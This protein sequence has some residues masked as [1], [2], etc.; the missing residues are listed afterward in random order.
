VFT[1]FQRAFFLVDKGS[2][3]LEIALQIFFDFS[4]QLPIYA[5]NHPT[6]RMIPNFSRIFAMSLNI[7]YKCMKDG[8]A[9]TVV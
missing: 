1:A 7:E 8:C 9:K 6:Q 2:V 4:E 5:Q 3:F